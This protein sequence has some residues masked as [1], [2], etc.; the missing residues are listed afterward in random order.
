MNAP[1]QLLNLILSN[2][3]LDHLLIFFFVPRTYNCSTPGSGVSISSEK[4]KSQ[5]L[6]TSFKSDFN[7]RTKSPELSVEDL[8]T[9]HMA[10]VYKQW[11]QQLDFL[12]RGDKLKD[13]LSSEIITTVMILHEEEHKQSSEVNL[14]LA[15]LNS[16]LV[17]VLVHLK[18]AGDVKKGKVVAAAAEKGRVAVVTYTKIA[19]GSADGFEKDWFKF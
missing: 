7:E 1:N 10:L 17:E 2:H 15:N 3:L 8:R 4:L 5:E 11:R 14:S 6:L 16:Q 13:D 9:S 12:R 18:R 19:V